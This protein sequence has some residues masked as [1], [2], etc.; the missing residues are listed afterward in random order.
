MRIPAMAMAKPEINATTRGRAAR[1]ETQARPA[2]DRE[3]HERDRHVTGANRPH[4][5]NMTCELRNN[6]KNSARPSPTR[7]QVHLISRP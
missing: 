7:R 2:D 6:A 1:A 4:S 5:P 3:E